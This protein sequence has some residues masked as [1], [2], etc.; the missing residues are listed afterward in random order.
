[1]NIIEIY[2]KY[3][4]PENLQMHM[5][6]VAA[7]GNLILD[8]WTGNE[9]NKQSIIRI[10]LMHDMGNI[11]KITPDQTNDMEFLKYRQQWIKQYGEND[12]LIN[13]IIA[14]QEGIT[15]IE[16]NIMDEKILSNNEKTAK[17]NSFE[18]KVCAYCDQRVTPTGVAP[19]KERLE[20][21]KQRHQKKGKGSMANEEK[22]ERL[23]KSAIE[24]ERQIMQHCSIKPEDINNET[25]SS[26][27][28]K[29]REFN[30]TE[31]EKESNINNDE[32]ERE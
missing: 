26:Y 4:I 1:M 5:L 15:E 22:A 28:E 6:R 2:K 31:P 9:I 12:H 20:E 21:L 23:I 10:L 24:I 18:V 17:N 3:Y 7:C 11:I 19:I 25:I 29:L 16:I 30:I 14:K 27:V 13:D 32:A 8:N